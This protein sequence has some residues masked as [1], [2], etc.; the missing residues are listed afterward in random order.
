LWL[1]VAVTAHQAAWE[2]AA[3]AYVMLHSRVERRRARSGVGKYLYALL[4]AK[5]QYP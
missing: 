5:Q 2:L 3:E 4:K 1:L